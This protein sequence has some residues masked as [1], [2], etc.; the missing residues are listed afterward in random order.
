MLMEV[1]DMTDNETKIESRGR[2]RKE[3]KGV[4]LWIPDIYV[5]TV[6]EF[7]EMLKQSSQQA[8]QQ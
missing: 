7:L 3:N 4:A 5:K 6:K 8:K 1:L 2:P